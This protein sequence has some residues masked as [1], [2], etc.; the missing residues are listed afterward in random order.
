VNLGPKLNFEQ[1]IEFW[2]FYNF[3]PPEMSPTRLSNYMPGR[4]PTARPWAGLAQ[5]EIQTGRD[6]S[7]LDRAELGGLNVH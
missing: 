2:A 7:G 1:K 5:P 4:G 3:A 6:I